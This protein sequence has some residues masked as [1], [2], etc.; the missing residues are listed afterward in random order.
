MVFQIQTSTPCRPGIPSG[1]DYI[2]PA[3]PTCRGGGAMP[4]SILK[5]P[6]FS[7]GSNDMISSQ[8]SDANTVS[9]GSSV[10]GDMAKLRIAQRL[11]TTMVV[12]TGV[13]S[14]MSL[15][16][17]LQV[18]W[19]TLISKFVTLKE[20]Y[21]IA[22]EVGET[23]DIAVVICSTS[24]FFISLL[25]LFFV[26]KL[27]KSQNSPAFAL[28]YLERTSFTRLVI[29]SFWF[30]GVMLMM[31]AVLLL[32]ALNPTRGTISKGVGLSL[33]VSAILFC[34]V[35]TLKTVM[36]WTQSSPSPTNVDNYKNFSTLV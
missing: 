6:P 35:A 31:T 24:A 11:L 32:C 18:N 16:F 28:E 10:S 30:L 29:Y 33:G 9:S 36:F 25:Q 34:S 15:Q 27:Q 19:S 5:K 20:F 1:S 12:A 17:F 3:S 26:M 13:S 14:V 7:V 4:H 8:T 22:S 23:L 21:Q 2:F